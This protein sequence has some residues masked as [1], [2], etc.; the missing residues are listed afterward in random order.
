MTVIEELV[1][2]EIVCYMRFE[3]SIS[4][5]IEN[6]IRHV[7]EGDQEEDRDERRGEE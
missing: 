6:I 5:T 3:Q 2:E 1:L 4:K 7:R